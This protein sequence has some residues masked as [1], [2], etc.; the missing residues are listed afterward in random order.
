MTYYGSLPV[1]INNLSQ[2]VTMARRFTFDL[3]VVIAVFLI[4]FSAH[5][6]GASARA[7]G[8]VMK[9]PDKTLLAVHKCPTADIQRAEALRRQL[10]ATKPTDP[11]WSMLNKEMDK[12]PA[13]C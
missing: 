3:F 2:G 11:K 12:L 13:G 9:C 6:C 1:S 8:A 4:N 10:T 7:D 5:A